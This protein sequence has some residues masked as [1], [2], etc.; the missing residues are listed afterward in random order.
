[1]RYAVIVA[2]LLTLLTMPDSARAQSVGASC[3]AALATAAAS[4]CNVNGCYVCT[5]MGGGVY[6]WLQQP[7]NLGTAA[8]SAGSS[9]TSYPA[10]AV[11][12]NTTLANLEVCDGSIWEIVGTATTSCGSPSGLSFT[13]V[14]SA[15]LG[16]SYTSNTA[17]ITFSGCSG[18]YSV[19]VTGDPTAQISVNGGAWTTSGAIASGQTLRAR[20]TSS[21][22]IST[23]STA[24]VTVGSLSTNWTVTTRAAGLL[25][26]ETNEG[27]IGSAI[28]G[29]AA[30]DAI[31][32]YDAGANGLAGTYKAILSDDTTDAVTRLTLSYP[33][34]SAFD[35]NTIAPTNLW[36]GSLAWYFRVMDGGPGNSFDHWS[37]TDATGHKQSTY[38]CS[39]WTAAGTGGLGWGWQSNT[40]W[41]FGSYNNCG[42]SHSLL[43]I[44]Q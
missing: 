22:S 23:T 28:G 37:G 2:F 11:R 17:T 15:S 24:T 3:T 26:F 25:A 33:I 5:S 38:T 29:L 21:G 19:S 13:N 12:F 40:N 16:T 1:M 43:C 8:A 10:G 4:A 30:A 6:T 34:V 9:C 31:C 32:Q 41:A 39:G 7:L 18:S 35:G 20:L 27:Y 36:S 14:T 44:Q 42:E